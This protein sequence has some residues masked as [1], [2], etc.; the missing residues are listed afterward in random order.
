M[1]SAVVVSRS[2]V[3]LYYGRRRRI[4]KVSIG[5]VWRPNADAAKK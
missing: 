1:F 4:D 3:N 5:H 2:I